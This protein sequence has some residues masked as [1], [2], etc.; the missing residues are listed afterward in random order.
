[1][2]LIAELYNMKNITIIDYQTSNMF[3]IKNA[4]DRLGFQSEITSDYKK[5]M[6]SDGIIL[7][8]VGSFPNA[9]SQLNKLGLINPI[10]DYINLNKPFLGI[11]LGL[12]LLFEESEEFGYTRGLGVLEG[13]VKS[14]KNNSKCL[15]V[16]HVGWNN[17][18][19]ENINNQK[20]KEFFANI[21]TKDKFYFVHSYFVEPKNSNYAI[22][23]T[24]YNNLSFCSSVQKN[25]LFACQWHPEKSGPKGLNLLSNFFRSF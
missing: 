8:G 4:I 18:Y 25:N 13:K 7:P 9:M 6:N 22:T 10:I 20:Q 5:I 14:L 23:T 19:L 2:G 3:S 1:M 21:N 11:C 15:K 12:Q 16:P 17:I 24:T